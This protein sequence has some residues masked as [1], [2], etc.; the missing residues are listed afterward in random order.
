MIFTL[1][2]INILRYLFSNKIWSQTDMIQGFY[3]TRIYFSS[4]NK[5]K[6]FTRFI[7][8]ICIYLC[9]ILVSNMISILNGYLCRLTV[10]LRVS[11]VDQIIPT[12][13]KHLSSPSEKWV[14]TLQKHPSSSSEKW[15]DTLQK[16]LSSSSE[17]WVDT[18]Q[19][20]LRSPSEK[21]VDW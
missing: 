12:L 10:I 9:I 2:Q 7:W 16:H 3:N 15:V 6:H 17:K 18:L 13:Q 19:K 5:T 8:V 14:D 4:D 11:L 21:W 1:C 20:H